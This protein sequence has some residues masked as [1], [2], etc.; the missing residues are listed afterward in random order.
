MQ[1]RIY[2][3]NLI[4]FFSF[5]FFNKIISYFVLYHKGYRNNLKY[6]MNDDHF[7]NN[8]QFIHKRIIY[9]VNFETLLPYAW[10]MNIDKTVGTK[11]KGHLTIISVQLP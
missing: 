2:A 4:L 7:Y 3:K 11:I 1:C 10:K 5:F 8:F 6:L 9:I